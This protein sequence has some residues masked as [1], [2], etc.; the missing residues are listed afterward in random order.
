MTTPERLL[1]LALAAC[2]ASAWSAPAKR[3]P[4][5]GYLY[6]GGGQQGTSVE[7]IAGGQFLRGVTGAHVS[8]KGVT[9]SV[10]QYFR[11]VR[12]LQKEQR[13]ELQRRLKELKDKRVAELPGTYKGRAVVFPGERF[14]RKGAG[15]RKRPE[16][17][18]DTEEMA[19][20]E[21]PAH[22]LLRE[23]EKK[24]LRELYQV[25]DAFFN[26]KSTKKKQPNAQIA[27]MVLVEVTVDRNA[28]PGDREL[29]LT[30]PFGL[31]NPMC[32]QVSHLREVREQEPNDPGAPNPLPKEPPV[33]LP[34]LLNGQIMPGDIDRFRFRAKQGQQLVIEAHARRLVPFLADAVPGWFQ[35][36]LTLYD[37]QG[38]EVAFADD[39][40][41]HPDPILF[42]KV[43]KSG[44]YELEIRDSIYRGREDFVYR[45]S[46]GELPFITAMF[47]LGGL[48]G[49]KT[50]AAIDGWNLPRK[51]LHLNTRPGS[52]RIRRT[53]LRQNKSSS[54]EVIYAVDALPACNEAEPNDDMTN[55]QP[56]DLPRIVD[57]RIGRPG[58]V[59]VFRFDARAGDEVVAEVQARR[60]H[61]PLDSLLRLTD[62]SGR[63]LEWN[64]DNVQKDG[65][66]HTDMGFLTHHA[67]SYLSA[68][69][70]EDGSYFVRLADTRSHGGDAFAYRLRISPPRPDFVLRVTPPGLSIPAGRV[71]P[72][73]VNAFRKDGFAGDIE[74]ALENAPAGFALS[75]GRI[76]GGRDHV[77]MTLTAPPKAPAQPVALNLVG[78]ALVDGE[79]ISRRAIP[80]ENVMQAFLWRHL[81]P[82]RELLVAVTKARWNTTAVEL[83]DSK[84]V[85]IPEGG[86]AQVRVK[87]PRFARQ[88]KIQLKLSEPVQGVTL[89]NVKSVPD[90]LE[91]QLKVEGVAA[92]PGFSGNLIVEAFGE[93]PAPKRGKKGGKG[94]GGGRQKRR[95]SLGVL[96]AISF[97]VVQR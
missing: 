92:K 47:P 24:S 82:S 60:L 22:P 50:V 71:V 3:E 66:L 70:P 96:P 58:D 7:I 89:Q 69:L 28:V 35:A 77:R 14:T 97:E 85:Q 25:A 73:T 84:P 52:E 34:V 15:K 88:R 43:P 33:D 93:F 38:S 53:A 1:L 48:E 27:E 4:H 44:E 63:V 10:V 19:A 30:T 29:R 78:R 23:L 76:P 2:F 20:V 49:A 9:A 75:G 5:I 83:A 51:R 81:A 80:S 36:T 17:G 11:P 39:Y 67:D 37:S 87:T 32:F 13:Q 94:K 31:T 12:N 45:I 79:T 59:D 86:T 62:A 42:W 72:I 46:V 68:R 57:G 54:N 16:K 65:H 90:G 64:D 6:P 56:V 61:S 41:F 91:F 74:L 21:L 55:A 18:K 8:G 95:V 40:R 26:Y